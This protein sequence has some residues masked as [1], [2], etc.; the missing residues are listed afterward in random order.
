M[1]MILI[2]GEQIKTFSGGLATGVWTMDVPNPRYRYLNAI[3]WA[4]SSSK[5]VKFFKKE[6]DSRTKLESESLT[7]KFK[8]LTNAMSTWAVSTSKMVGVM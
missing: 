3:H 2:N 1:I 8:S 6:W 5:T 4:L 7:Q